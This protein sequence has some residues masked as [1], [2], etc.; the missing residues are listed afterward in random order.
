MCAPLIKIIPSR[1]RVLSVVSLIFAPHRNR[2]KIIRFKGGSGTIPRGLYTLVQK[3]A[4]HNAKPA[5]IPQRF[6]LCLLC[7]S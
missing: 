5:T 2:G 3:E 6:F 7:V 1:N 4:M